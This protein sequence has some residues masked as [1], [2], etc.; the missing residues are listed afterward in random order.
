M[1]ANQG[2]L[3]DGTKIRALLAELGRRC[4]ACGTSVEMI[5]VGGGAMALAYD[6]D[7]RSTGD[8]DA[9]FEPK[10]EVYAEAR[11]MADELGLP[12][13]WLNDGMKGFLPESPDEGEQVVE[14]SEG[15]RVVIPSPEYLFAMKAMSARLN[16]DDDDLMLL[17]ELAGV[18]TVEDAYNVVE[19]YYRPERIRA[20]TGLYLQSIYPPTQ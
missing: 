9:V 7:R 6:P 4:A 8:V 10:M 1:S 20:K 5:V 12:P 17:G 19:R 15:L 3:L 14:T 18:R 11:K 2:V 16:R 13:D